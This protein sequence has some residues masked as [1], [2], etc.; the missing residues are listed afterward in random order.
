[1]KGPNA[2]SDTGTGGM[3]VAKPMP[4]FA[5]RLALSE[6]VEGLAKP[7]RLELQEEGIRLVGEV[8]VGDPFGLTGVIIARLY[9]SG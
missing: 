5:P 9:W 1:M 4:E 7:T 6:R 3:I 2:E 8:R